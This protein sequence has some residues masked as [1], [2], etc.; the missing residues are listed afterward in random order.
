M[1]H[2]IYTV[3]LFTLILFSACSDSS[4]KVPDKQN[5]HKPGVDAT[6]FG[7]VEVTITGIGSQKM[8]ASIHPA[9]RV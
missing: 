3:A 7:L 5:E 1:K 6:T 8:S 4:L 9:A 2:L